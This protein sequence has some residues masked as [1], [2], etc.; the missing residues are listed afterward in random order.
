LL[1]L[2]QGA[3]NLA[4][5]D[6]DGVETNGVNGDIQPTDTNPNEA[7]NTEIIVTS[8]PPS[9]SSSP[10]TSAR[11]TPSLLMFDP[12]N[13]RTGVYNDT[14]PPESDFSVVIKPM[15]PDFRRED[16]IVDEDE[17]TIG[18]IIGEIGEDDDIVYEVQFRDDRTAM[19][20][21]HYSHPFSNPS[22][23]CADLFSYLLTNYFAIRMQK[24]HLK[25]IKLSAKVIV[26]HADNARK[27][28]PFKFY[29]TPKK[30]MG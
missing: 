30:K 6:M 9:P 8:Q 27:Q 26:D 24:R 19:V 29:P 17:F 21:P 1:C 14:I 18:G 7:I 25:S 3:T 15:G 16:Y 23:N 28:D 12:T 22:D 10:L 2:L 5:M 4:A 11:S 20:Y 13:Y